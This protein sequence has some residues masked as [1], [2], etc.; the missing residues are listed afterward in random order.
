MEETWKEIK[1]YEGVYEVS[2]L[3]RVRRIDSII[4]HSLG[5]KRKWAGRIRKLQIQD[6]I[7]VKYSFTILCSGGIHKNA[8]IHRLVAE[9]FI[10]NPDKKPCVNHIDG[11]GLNN[12]IDNLEW[13]TYSE[14]EKHSYM[15]LGKKPNLNSLGKLGIL[16]D[17]AKP[18]IRKNFDGK[19][20]GVWGSASEA[21]R[22]LN[23]SQAR[24]SCNARKESSTCYHSTFHYISKQRYFKL[25]KTI[26]NEPISIRRKLTVENVLEIRKIKSTQ[27]ISDEKIA[28]QFGVSKS[29]IRAIIIRK[30]WKNI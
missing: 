30:I 18:V 26:N 17:D 1:G 2:N 20:I 8:S 4:G 6:R 15:V 3:G 5:G 12:R 13:V 9:A 24:I 28:K 11:N 23:A 25:I 29:T 7:T 27:K 14:N 22:E 10:Q 21:G 16:S 19:I